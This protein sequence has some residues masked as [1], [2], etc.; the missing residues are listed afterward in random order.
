MTRRSFCVCLN[1]L[2]NE[3]N[4]ASLSFSFLVACIPL[5]FTGFCAVSGNDIFLVAVH[6]LGHAL[7]LEHSNDP[8][9]IMA[10]F[11]QWMD[12]DNFEL[13]DDD[14]R[15]VQQLYGALQI[16]HYPN[17]CPKKRYIFFTGFKCHYEVFQA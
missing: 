17:Q 8:S 7:G 11:Y 3:E 15:G 13:P 14:R 16:V 9:A 12:T 10:P 1:H 6:E 4:I 5:H 2:K